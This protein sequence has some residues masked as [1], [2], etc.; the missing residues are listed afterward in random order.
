MRFLVTDT[1]TQTQLMLGIC[2]DVFLSTF[3]CFVK[4]NYCF[5]P[6]KKGREKSLPFTP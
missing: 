5:Y 3:H 4:A 2:Q 6:T 1:D